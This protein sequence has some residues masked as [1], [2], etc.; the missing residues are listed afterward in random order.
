MD[1]LLI[2]I[3]IILIFLGI[4]GSFMPVLPGPILSWLGLLTLFLREE[5][6]VSF[7]FITITFFIA[8]TIFIVDNIITVLGV[9]KNGGSKR[10]VIGSFIG[11]LIGVF[12]GPFGILFGSFL[13]AFAGEF[14][15]QMNMKKSIKVSLG[16][17]L[18]LIGGASIKFLMSLVF[19]FY[20][21]YLVLQKL[22]PI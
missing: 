1:F 7:K 21:I 20:Y 9:R 10:S 5:K 19:L 17:I 18:G 6:L 16:A 22:Y 13:G 4:A 8:I 14:S 15:N 2:F 3:G 11:L 12:M